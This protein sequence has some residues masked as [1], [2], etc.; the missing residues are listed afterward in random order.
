MVG[1]KRLDRGVTKELLASRAFF[2]HRYCQL[3]SSKPLQVYQELQFI[4][5]SHIGGAAWETL[6]K[7]ELFARHATHGWKAVGNEYLGQH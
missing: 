7:L 5:E 6:E 3:H 2:D 4:W 1:V